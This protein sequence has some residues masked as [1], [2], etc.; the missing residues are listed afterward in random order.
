MRKI[1]FQKNSISKN[2]K[3]FSSQKEEKTEK[4]GVVQKLDNRREGIMQMG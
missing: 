1:A 4:R 2:K 3:A